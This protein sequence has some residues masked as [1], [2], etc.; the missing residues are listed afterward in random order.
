MQ[1]INIKEVIHIKFK[2]ERENKN[3]NEMFYTVCVFRDIFVTI[4][5][6]C[7]STCDAMNKKLNQKS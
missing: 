2:S 5:I 1:R 3:N 6:V 4:N 7:G